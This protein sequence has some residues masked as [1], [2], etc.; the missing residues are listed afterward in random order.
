MGVIF[1]AFM[2]RPIAFSTPSEKN[3]HAT[4]GVAAFATVPLPTGNGI[5]G[6]EGTR[7][8]WG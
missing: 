7:I 2:E 8:F 5:S 1:E 3:Y 4:L 6:W